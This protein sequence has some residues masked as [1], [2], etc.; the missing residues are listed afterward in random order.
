MSGGNEMSDVIEMPGG[1]Q[2]F[3]G[4]GKHSAWMTWEALIQAEP[5]II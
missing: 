1:T 2:L 3:G 4:S 5:D